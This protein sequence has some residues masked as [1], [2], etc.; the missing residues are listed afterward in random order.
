[1]VAVPKRKNE[2]VID[3]E[4]TL[5]IPELEELIKFEQERMIKYI[6]R[7]LAGEVSHQGKY[8]PW[9]KRNEYMSVIEYIH[10]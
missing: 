8:S 6:L 10:R 7:D 3:L 5:H 4:L 9:T 1:M 2:L